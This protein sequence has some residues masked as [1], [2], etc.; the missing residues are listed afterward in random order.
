[1]VVAFRGGRGACTCPARQQQRPY[2]ALPQSY[3]AIEEHLDIDTHHNTSLGLRAPRTKT[4]KKK[5]LQQRLHEHATA[6]R[7]YRC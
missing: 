3:P 7:L 2:H 5:G 1:M 6:V 4:W